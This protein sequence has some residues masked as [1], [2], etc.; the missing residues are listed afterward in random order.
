MASRIAD[1][2]RMD[3]LI[4]HPHSGFQWR[5]VTGPTK[6]DL[7]KLGEDYNL[8]STSVED[9]LDPGHLP[10]LEKIENTIFVILRAFDD[11]AAMEANS[12]TSLTRKIAILL[13]DECL[14]SIHRQEFP[15]L[16]NLRGIWSEN[17]IN[18]SGRLFT[19]IAE[20]MLDSF[21]API[22]Q[23]TVEMEDVEEKVYARMRQS[24]LLSRLYS[25][26]RRI[27]LIRRIVWMDR[28][29]I[30]RYQ[31]HFI[32]TPDVQECLDT[33]ADLLF[34]LDDLLE[35][36]NG[37]ISLHLSLA[38][39]RTNEVMRVLTV[40]SVFFLPLTFISGIY[41]MNFQNMP[42]LSW[43]YGYPASL[44]TMVVITVVIFFWF[45]R[46]GWMR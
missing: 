10:K 20:R 8:H 22:D 30:E 42:E 19:A 28:E 27:W 3:Q 18:P 29:V 9:C 35:S 39:H 44:A 41:G 15:F 11:H 17:K 46:R 37:L 38:S 14:I 32:T 40:F 33:A 5:D 1:S 34:L 6:S 24:D 36:T 4:H 2:T 13:G 25:L 31:I 43:R 16:N 26:K 21:R 7:H 45:S 23:L 12:V